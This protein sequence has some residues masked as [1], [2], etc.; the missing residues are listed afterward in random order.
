MLGCKSPQFVT[1]GRMLKSL[2]THL[3]DAPFYVDQTKGKV[4][5]DFGNS[6]PIDENGHLGTD[7]LGTLFVAV[8]RDT[9]PS[10][11]CSDDLLWLG[12]IKYRTPNWYKNTAGV[13]VFPS[14]GTISPQ[15]MDTINTK[16]LV[17]AEV[18]RDVHIHI[19]DCKYHFG[20]IFVSVRNPALYQS[21]VNLKYDVSNT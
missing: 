3:Q 20:V 9:H 17:V 12:F 13:Q 4:F 19:T 14:L 16:P 21:G 8:P 15:D 2:S 11:N 7:D 18:L 10:L 6:L 1:H 5:V